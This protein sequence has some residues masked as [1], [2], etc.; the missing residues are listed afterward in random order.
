MLQQTQFIWG[1]EIKY[2]KLF[3]VTIQILECL[4]SLFDLSVKFRKNL[5][6]I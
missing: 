4:S 1:V 6:A 2:M 5:H 3:L